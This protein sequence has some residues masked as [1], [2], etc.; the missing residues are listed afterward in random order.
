MT[1]SISV[2][3]GKS[4]L[5][6]IRQNGLSA[7]QIQMMAGA[8]GGPKWFTL[9]GLDKYIFGE[10]F[11]NRETPLYTIG[12]SAGAWRM[13][14]FAQK[15]PVAAITRLATYYSHETYSQKPTVEEI[16]QKARI[17][18]NKLLGEDGAKEILEN[19]VIQTHLIVARAKGFA[20]SE[21]KLLQLTGLISSAGLNA[22]SA[23]TLP[24]FFERYN[25]FTKND[26]LGFDHSHF[27]YDKGQTKYA[28]LTV[29]NIK[30]VLLASGAIPLVLKGISEI[31][32]VRKGIYRDGGIIDY[33]FDVAFPKK[34]LVLYP[35]FHP[36]I[37]TGWFDKG[38][39][40]RHAKAENFDNVVMITPS[41]SH[42]KSLPYQKI[43][44]RSDFE[45]LD[46][47]TRIKYW[48]K[49]LSES[50][51]L[52]EDFSKLIEK[53]IG[54]NQALPIEPIL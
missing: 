4:A 28:G 49:V 7:E 27:N 48:Q 37:K 14:C 24:W 43:T 5:K 51:K 8:S 47:D 32:G 12:S 54:L 6:E 29:N 46:T 11:K 18:V 13:A 40:Y 23:K 50:E 9:F 15:D 34:G 16:S 10:F 45:K 19:P 44:D 2:Y 21:N 20:K 26:F 3:A 17:L 36:I 31:E 52:A 25:F 22:I 38:L 1:S 33:H 53:G 42:I 35:H 39:K 30:E 41:E